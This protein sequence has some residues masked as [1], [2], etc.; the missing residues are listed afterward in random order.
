VVFSQEEFAHWLLPRKGVVSS[1]VNVTTRKKKKTNLRG[2]NEESTGGGKGKDEDD[3]ADEDEEVVTDFC[4]YY[5]LHSSVLGNPKHTTLHAAYSF[6]NVANTISLEELMR[7]C[8]ILAKNE[9]HDVFNA[10]NLMENETFLS[11]LKFGMGDGNLQY[12]VYNW[13]C[14]TM[15]H[16]DVGLVLL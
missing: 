15:E 16:G 4:S 7:D 5:H 1:F 14:P 2:G 8:L 10:L 11:E 3:D 6:Y 12:Y 9:G 13:L